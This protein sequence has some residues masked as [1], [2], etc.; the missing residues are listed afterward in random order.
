MPDL[1]IGGG[2]RSGVPR[3]WRAGAIAIAMLGVA[4]VVAWFIYRRSVAYD[5]PGGEVRGALSS[6]QTAPG[7]P[8]T[9]MYGTASLA[10]SGAI[11]VL[12]LRG[13]AHAIG[14]AHGRLLAPY[15]A[16]VVR[17]TSP[18]IDGTVGKGGWFGGT[19]H[20]MR[21]AWQWRF[22]DDGLIEQDRRMVAGMTRGAGASGVDLEYD[23][24]VRG[25]AVVD[26]G[27]PSPRTAEEHSVARSLTVVARQQAAPARVWI[28]RTFALPGLDDGGEAAIPVLTIAHPEG[29][30]AWAGVGWPGELGV[31]TGVNAQQIAVMVN[32]A[33]TAD[34]RTTRTARPVAHLARTILEQAKTLDE[35]IKII[36]TTPTL[37]A[38]VIIVVDGTS[39]TWVLV[40]R[41]PSKAIVERHPK[42]SA[43][44]DVL[45]TN[46]LS[47]DPQNDRARRMLPTTSRAER[48]TR[49]S[50]AP[51]ADVNALVAILRDQRG[52]DDSQRPP[53][54]RG[55]ID[56]GRAA[57]TII[58]D[59][60]SL[61]LWVADPLTHGRMRAFDLRHELRGEGDR[62]APPADIAGEANV[63]LDRHAILASARAD[64]R[65][66]RG[67]LRDGKRE[68]AAEACARARARAPA[69]PEAIEL[70]AVVAQLRGDL[71]Y[72]RT[73]FQVWLDG[74]ADDPK[75]EERA[76]AL[77]AR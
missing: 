11:P 34:V 37:G 42:S 57:H 5:M 9:L 6:T 41:T 59:P 20:A 52:V 12:R 53:G 2:R 43:F 46:A 4:I 25:Q 26:V 45:T 19:T 75:G 66:A 21:L 27:A 68:R 50:R 17:A 62:P 51:L 73:A 13:D 58:L 16:P 64:L 32:P 47:S 72:A 56:D 77:L 39:G 38:A 8:P 7:A 74:G 60:A 63:D 22:I 71:A 76:R 70:D 23:D 61:E 40:E 65:I 18:S 15:L 54:H 55:V 1:V 29:R 69:L 48:A 35:A 24:L 10:W 3:P 14:A 49:L 30:I 28:G 36:E 44:G 31:V 33:R 67:A